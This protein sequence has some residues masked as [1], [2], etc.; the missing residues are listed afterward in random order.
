MIL[1]RDVSVYSKQTFFKQEKKKKGK[2][3][4]RYFFSLVILKIIVC[5]WIKI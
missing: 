4:K 2:Y 3:L 1:D 5:L